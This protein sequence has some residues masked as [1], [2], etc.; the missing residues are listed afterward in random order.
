MIKKYYWPA[1]KAQWPWLLSYLLLNALLAL[2]TWIYKLPLTFFLDFIRF[3]ILPLIIIITYQTMQTVKCLQQLAHMVTNKQWQ[4]IKPHNLIAKAYYAA[5]VKIIRQQQIVQQQSQLQQQQHRDYLET[6]SHE[7]KT[8]LTTLTILADNHEQIDSRIVQQQIDQI[9]YQLN[10]LLNYERLADFHHDLQFKLVNLQQLITRIIKQYATF[11]INKKITPVI[12]VTKDATLLTDSKWVAFIIG[13]LL[14]NAIKYSQPHRQI[15][16]NWQ[17]HQLIIKDEGIG[18]ASD[19]L[20]RIFEPGF[21]GSNGR[22]L[23]DATGMG[24]YIVKT[25]CQQL[26]IKITVSSRLNKGT[27]FKLTFP[28]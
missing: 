7:L 17:N 16:I 18:I 28:K 14:N 5:F 1:L 24:L 21:T 9:N 11:F 2:L 3:S 6:W 8:P 15:I 25:V 12:T 13:Q 26:H 27:T 19:E 22:K 4:T 10:L 23:G 20:P